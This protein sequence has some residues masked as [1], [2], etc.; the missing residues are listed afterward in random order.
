MGFTDINSFIHYEY[1]FYLLLN[2]K[3]KFYQASTSEMF[4]KVQ[5]T[6]TEKTPFYPR[7]HMECLFFQSNINYG[8][9]LQ[10]YTSI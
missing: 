2:F 10:Y 9:I 7:I 1:L 6:T 4:G 3:I 5:H 8:G